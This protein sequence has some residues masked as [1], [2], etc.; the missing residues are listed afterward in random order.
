MNATL[1]TEDTYLSNS[2]YIFRE[3]EDVYLIEPSKTVFKGDYI[4]QRFKPNVGFEDRY[5]AVGNL[6]LSTNGTFTID[7]KY[8]AL[9]SVNET[10]TF[11]VGTK[12]QQKMRF[13]MYFL[14]SPFVKNTSGQIISTNSAWFLAGSGSTVGHRDDIYPNEFYIENRYYPV[15][16]YFSNNAYIKVPYNGFYSYFFDLN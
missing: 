9:H 14:Y 13:N 10:L 6:I 4:L 1:A 2:E 12:E 3:E 11:E 15:N 8:F 16:L 5:I 7:K